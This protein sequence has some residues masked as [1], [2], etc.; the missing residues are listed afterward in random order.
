M[1]GERRVQHIMIIFNARPEEE[2]LKRE[3]VML[4]CSREQK[5]VREVRAEAVFRLEIMFLFVQNTM[6][7]FFSGRH[8]KR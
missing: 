3:Q 7:G 6:T 8:C 5:M 1:N 4:F 2:A